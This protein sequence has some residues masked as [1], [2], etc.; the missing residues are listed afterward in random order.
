MAEI[1]VPISCQNT[2]RREAVG[3]CQQECERLESQ[4]TLERCASAER[5]PF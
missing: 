4:G 2:Y 5:Q 1:V 3:T